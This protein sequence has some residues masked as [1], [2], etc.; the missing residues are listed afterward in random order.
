MSDINVKATIAAAKV[1]TVQF[2][3]TRASN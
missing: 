2:I 1:G 3:E